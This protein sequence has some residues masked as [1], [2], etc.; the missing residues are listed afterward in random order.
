MA[1][2]VTVDWAHLTTVAG[3][4]NGVASEIE[5]QLTTLRG[6]LDALGDWTGNAKSALDALYQQWNTNATQLHTALTEIA[7]AMNKAASNYEAGETA[8]TSIFQQG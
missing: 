6:N 2:N 8:N 4:V 5:T 3:Q 1:T 7:T